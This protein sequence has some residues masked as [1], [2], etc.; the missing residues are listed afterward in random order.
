MFN[1]PSTGSLKKST[2]KG[3]LKWAKYHPK[4]EPQ[5]GKKKTSN[6]MHLSPIFILNKTS[7]LSPLLKK[8]LA[9]SE[10]LVQHDYCS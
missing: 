4:K 7:S 5:K 9:R 6:P 8:S 1:Y 3:E 2:Q 10:S